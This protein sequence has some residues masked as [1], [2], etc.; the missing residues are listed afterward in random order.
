MNGLSLGVRE[1]AAWCILFAND[2][3]LCNTNCNKVECKVEN[4][5][6]LED[7]GLKISRGKMIEYKRFWDERSIEVKFQEEIIKRVIKFKYLG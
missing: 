2:I 7:R 1:G 4:W 3:V 6:V 5:E